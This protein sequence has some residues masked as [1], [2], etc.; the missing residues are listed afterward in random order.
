MCYLRSLKF[1]CATAISS[2]DPTNSLQ[3]NRIEKPEDPEPST[4]I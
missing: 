3:T 2:N 1:C 4:P